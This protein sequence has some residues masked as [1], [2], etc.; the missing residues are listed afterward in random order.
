M[1]NRELKFTEQEEQYIDVVEKLINNPTTKIHIQFLSVG[2]NC[3]ISN[4]EHHFK[5]LLDQVGITL[6][7]G[8]FSIKSRLREKFLE[9]LKELVVQKNNEDIEE[10]IEDIS[11]REIE[12]INNMKNTL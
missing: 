5:I 4:E 12:L 1:F 7:N 10:L 9:H 3:L 6:Q 2:R 11:S 8:V